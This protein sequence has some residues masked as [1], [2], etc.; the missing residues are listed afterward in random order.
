VST[1]RDAV[2]E[3][4]QGNALELCGNNELEVVLFHRP[5]LSASEFDSILSMAPGNL[6]RV[7]FDLTRIFSDRDGSTFG[8]GSAIVAITVCDPDLRGDRRGLS[9]RI[10]AD[11]VIPSESS[12][13]RR[14]VFAGDLTVACVH[15]F[16][17]CRDRDRAAD[18][19]E[20][21]GAARFSDVECVVGDR[22]VRQLVDRANRGAVFVFVP[23]PSSWRFVRDHRVCTATL[24]ALLLLFGLYRDPEL[25]LWRHSN[26]GGLGLVL[27]VA[28][29]LDRL[30]FQRKPS[31]SRVAVRSRRSCV[32]SRHLHLRRTVQKRSALRRN[33]LV[34]H[35]LCS[36]SFRCLPSLPCLSRT[37]LEGA[38]FG[39]L[40]NTL[41]AGLGLVSSSCFVEIIA[42][43]FPY[44]SLFE[45]STQLS[46]SHR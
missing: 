25:W 30:V 5:T 38:T 39:P 16:V 43:L 12:P 35:V 10:P 42:N 8:I 44:L 22:D 23:E 21:A 34:D 6:A 17:L 29:S 37:T 41:T 15:R 24:C 27:L 26:V 14:I 33:R 9:R 18:N 11:R 13:T 45:T 31:F 40:A 28:R 1:T 7:V 36:L 20:Y 2:V 3:L 4:D 19:R 32:G 46:L